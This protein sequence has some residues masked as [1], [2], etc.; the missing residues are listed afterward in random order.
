MGGSDSGESESN[1]HV[2]RDMR[3]DRAEWVGLSSQRQCYAPR[4]DR[5]GAHTDSLSS[6]IG[7]HSASLVWRRRCFQGLEVVS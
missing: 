1:A 4:N 3:S 7:T 6:F 5:G 2:A